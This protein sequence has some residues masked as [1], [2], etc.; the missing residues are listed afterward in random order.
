MHIKRSL[1]ATHPSRV[2]S[3]MAYY[4][5]TFN[6]LQWC[7]LDSKVEERHRMLFR[8]DHWTPGRRGGWCW[9]WLKT[10]GS[11]IRTQEYLVFPPDLETI[12]RVGPFLTL[13]ASPSIMTWNQQNSTDGHGRGCKGYQEEGGLLMILSHTSQQPLSNVR[14]CL[15]HPLV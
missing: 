5:N 15:A 2:P 6:C 1:C 11:T 9:S 14:G 12:H 8:K 7:N 4:I 3:H 10:Q 13:H